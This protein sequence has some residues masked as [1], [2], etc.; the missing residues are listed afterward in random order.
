[1]VSFNSRT[2]SHLYIK[3]RKFLYGLSGSILSCSKV[4]SC[5]SPCGKRVPPITRMF[6]AHY[7]TNIALLVFCFFFNI[8]HIFPIIF[9]KSVLSLPTLALRYPII[10][11]KSCLDK[12]TLSLLDVGYINSLCHPH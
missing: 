1:M 10:I 11:S 7:Q 12:K 3:Q 4:T 9:S 5:I 2:S 6:V 8:F